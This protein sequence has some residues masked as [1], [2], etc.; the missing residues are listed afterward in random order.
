MAIKVKHEGNVTSRIV[1]SAV[2][3]TGRPNA[4]DTN[5]LA[6]KAAQENMAANRQLQGAHAN[7]TAPYAPAAQLGHASMQHAPA[8]RQSALDYQRQTER[9]ALLQE[10]SLA[11]IG[12]EA[13]LREQA[14]VSADARKLA[15]WKEQYSFGQRAEIDN[16]NNLRDEV[17]SRDDFTEEQ[18]KDLL[19]QI[20]ARKFGIQPN[21]F[22]KSQE[23]IDAETFDPAKDF[24]QNSYTDA[25]GN[26]WTRDP[27]GGWRIGQAA[28]PQKDA[29]AEA[30]KAWSD[31]YEKAVQSLVPQ[32]MKATKPDP[33]TKGV[34]QLPLYSSVDEVIAAAQKLAGKMFVE[35]QYKTDAE[36]TA[37]EQASAAEQAAQ[38][39]AAAQ[40]AAVEAGQAPAPTPDQLAEAARRGEEIKKNLPPVTAEQKAEAERSFDAWRKQMEARLAKSKKP[41]AQ[42]VVQK[43]TQDEMENRWGTSR[44]K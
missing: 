7:P 23:E 30:Y 14:A 10:N 40:N 16:L 42:A 36:K 41:A 28:Q 39:Q 2:G 38:E 26:I 15:N 8:V 1:A 21:T 19:R 20:D 31:K 33:A 35:P 34:T 3:G 18:K 11:R 43:E 27:R 6:Q 24:A 5:A 13:E 32:L 9:D 12:K 17:M 22:P 44:R 29:T 4:E 25:Q 37:A